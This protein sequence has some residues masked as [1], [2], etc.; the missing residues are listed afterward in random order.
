LRVIDFGTRL[1]ANGAFVDTAAVMA[2]LDLVVTSDTA[3]AHLAGALG[4]P[5]WLALS[6]AADWRW[7]R[8]GET[9]AWYPTMRLFRQ[10][11][12]GDWDGVFRRMAK[13]LEAGQNQTQFPMDIAPGELVDK[14]TILEIKRDQVGDQRKLHNIRIELGALLAVKA[15]TIKPSPELERLTGHLM[16][17]NASLWHIVDE[18][19]THEKKQDFGTRFNELARSVAR[20]ND[21]RAVIKKSINRLLGSRIVEEKSYAEK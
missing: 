3:I 2:H 21:E 8:K 4:V 15:G 20:E 6:R 16:A 17:V 19:H 7:L 5:V 12:W 9:S 14:I 18:I 10:E 11:R 13:A 1:D